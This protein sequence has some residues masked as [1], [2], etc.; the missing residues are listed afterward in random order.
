MNF[1]L[2]LKRL[3]LVFWSGVAIFFTLILATTVL[4]NWPRNEGKAGYLFLTVGVP[5][6]L[7]KLTCWI[8]DGFTRQP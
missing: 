3:S 6:G 7:H 1:A 2:G 4:E 5:W 8:V